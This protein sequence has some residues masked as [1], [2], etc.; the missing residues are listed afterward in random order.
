MKHFASPKFLGWIEAE[1]VIRRYGFSESGGLRFANPPYRATHFTR[2][3]WLNGPGTLAGARPVTSAAC[4]LRPR[5]F[6]A[7]ESFYDVMYHAPGL[8]Q[9]VRDAC[10][11]PKQGTAARYLI[12]FVRC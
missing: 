8:K 2:K 6:G 10:D 4:C 3:Q 11:Y 12:E 1:D 7:R 5:V 9:R